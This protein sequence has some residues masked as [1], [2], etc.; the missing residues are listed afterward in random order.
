[1]YHRA[2]K[3]LTTSYVV[4]CLLL[5]AAGYLVWPSRAAWK[6][7]KLLP[8]RL[9]TLQELPQA[10]ATHDA[11]H[12]GFSECYHLSSTGH[13]QRGANVVCRRDHNGVLIEQYNFL[14]EV[15][16]PVHFADV[17]GD[18]RDEL[19]AWIT[20]NDTA[21]VEIRTFDDQR[22]ACFPAVTKD[23][24]SNI[25]NI[26]VWDCHGYLL[27]ARDIDGD[28]LKDLVFAVRT[29]YAGSPRGIYAF[30]LPDGK[31]LWHEQM[32]AFPTGQVAADLDGDGLPEYV[33]GCDT[34]E[35]LRRPINGTQD[36]VAY[37]MV[38][39]HDGRRL[40]REVLGD[41]GTFVRPW[42]FR[43]EPRGPL[44][45]GVICDRR[46]KEAQA[47]PSEVLELEFPR[48]T[49]RRLLPP[50]PF[51]LNLGAFVDLDENG[52]YELLLIGDNATAY[53]YRY[54]PARG[55]YVPGIERE[56]RLAAGR[57][58]DAIVVHDLDQDGAKEILVD[59]GT[60]GS[61]VLDARLRL[62]ATAPDITVIHVVLRG[63]ERPLLLASYVGRP[64]S[65]LMRF[66]RTPGR[67]RNYA[68]LVVP[69][70]ALF[71]LLVALSWQFLLSFA[72]CRTLPALAPTANWVRLDRSLAI[73]ECSQAVTDK[74]PAPTP[75]VSL[76][77]VL[78]PGAAQFVRSWIGRHKASRAEAVR[79]VELPDRTHSLV[80]FEWYPWPGPALFRGGVLLWRQLPGFG[81]PRSGEW[82]KLTRAMVHDAKNPLSASLNIVARLRRG[83]QASHRGDG[84]AQ[85]DLAEVEAQILQARNAIVRLLSFMDV[86]THTP[87][88]CDVNALI[89]EVCE[90]F[91]AELAAGVRLR[92]ELS[93]NLP[94][95]RVTHEALRMALR[96]II[97]N[98]VEAVGPQ[99]SIVVSSYTETR[100]S[101]ESRAGESWIVIEILDD[102]PGIPPDLRPNLFEPG[103][104]T[105]EGG[106]GLGLAITKEI[107]QS[108]Q[109]EVRVDSPGGHGTLV[110]LSIPVRHPTS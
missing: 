45:C 25:E 8:Y 79:D 75:T 104:S 105:K 85:E 97:Q 106:S 37:L 64:A 95:V 6:D 110:V 11:D 51:A 47:L 38:F 4:A 40:F 80:V 29:G 26:G 3:R 81:L 52:V 27:D 93:D 83:D 103:I 102:G 44:R 31:L 98:A 5:L 107:M 50:L 20:R 82:M 7:P 22:I 23:E 36:N 78:P 96:N 63:K 91:R 72:A 74:L 1:M 89:E 32:G 100:P 108:L 77:E 12:N 71:V 14:G 67:W 28:G 2:R 73:R 92:L 109:G 21:F 58:A 48:L 76:Q 59:T 10:L 84:K 15:K 53:L 90:Q 87:R 94:L 66:E 69:P 49:L 33:L 56:L 42:L 61:F 41:K 24:Y 54:D 18:G 55:M 101:S 60:R 43:H 13:E 17:V 46:I 16:S 9:V 88:P 68:A 34:P 70:A 99:G 30:R 39:D 19:V 57:L 65:S 62:L 35:N 86:T